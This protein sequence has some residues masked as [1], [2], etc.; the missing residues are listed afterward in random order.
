MA[1]V[2]LVTIE[3][4]YLASGNI[5][6]NLLSPPIISSLINLI[7]IFTFLQNVWINFIVLSI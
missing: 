6:G 3:R 5:L 2:T 4:N 1:M 7:I